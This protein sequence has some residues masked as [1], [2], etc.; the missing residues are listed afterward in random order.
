[1]SSA[2]TYLP[3]S[4]VAP[5]FLLITNMTQ[6]IQ[7]VVTTSTSNSYVVGQLVRLS[8][9]FP[10]GMFQADNLTGQILVTDGTNFTL[11]INSLQFDAYKTPS[12]F[13]EQPATMSPS[14]CR[15]IYDI[16]YEPFHS[17]NGQV[18]N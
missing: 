11:D 3:G 8:V 7:M 17:V 6:A 13:Q 12:A 16:S 15:N 5:P 1:M 14:G 10:Y 9:P 2:N 4:P 18:G